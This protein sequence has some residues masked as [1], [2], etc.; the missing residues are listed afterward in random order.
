VVH[1]VIDNTSCEHTAHASALEHQAYLIH[2]YCLNIFKNNWLQ[3]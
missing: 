2:L 3:K 1:K